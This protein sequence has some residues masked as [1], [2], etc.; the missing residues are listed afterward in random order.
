[1]EESL[2]RPPG[3][4]PLRLAL[5]QPDIPQNT[6]T[7]LRLAA[8]MGVAVD[9][10]EPCGFVLD[11]RR[12]RR[13][14]MDYLD[15]VEMVRHRAW[16]AFRDGLS[17]RLVLLTTGAE[18]SYLDFAFAPGD[19]LLLGRESAGV[20]DAVHAAAHARV[21]VPMVPGARSL[22][23]AVAAAMVLGEA[24]RQLGAGAAND[25]SVARE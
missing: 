22:N 24:L 6:G 13:A 10:I 17:G 23:V 5:Y 4:P 21:A 12:L 3:R 20:P 11:D 1:M 16:P 18:R 8:C 25:G 7:I 15:G 9:V 19:V 2:P 14:G